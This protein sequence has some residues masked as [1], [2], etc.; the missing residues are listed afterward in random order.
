M[1]AVCAWV[2][3]TECANCRN[4][5]CGHLE[6]V[7]DAAGDIGLTDVDQDINKV[8]FVRLVSFF[9]HCDLLLEAGAVA[10]SEQ[11]QV[12]RCIC[13]AL[14]GLCHSL[15][16]YTYIT[17]ILCALQNV[18]ISLVLFLEGIQS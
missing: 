6:G 13:V 2:S 5:K 10:V 18:R 16:S 9:E 8:S 4:I 11:D 17:C 7:H 3:R 12:P 1:V 14:G 15:G